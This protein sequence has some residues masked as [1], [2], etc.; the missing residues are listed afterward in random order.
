[1]HPDKAAGPDGLNPSFYQRLWDV[2]RKQV[3]EECREWWMHG[4]LSNDVRAMNIILL[5]KISNPT[6]TS[7]LRPISLCN[8]R[9]RIMAK[10]LANRLRRVMHEIIPDEQSTFIKG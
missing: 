1:M 5:P 8:V 6:R 4:E 9:Y 2:V 3:V 10:V 7:D